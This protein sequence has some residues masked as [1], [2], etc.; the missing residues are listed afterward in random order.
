VIAEAHRSRLAVARL[1]RVRGAAR[2]LLAAFIVV[3]PCVALAAGNYTV[4][5]R[6]GKR[7]NKIQEALQAENYN[8]AEE[9]LKGFTMARLNPYERALVYQFWGYVEAG[10][11][12]YQASADYF[13]K[14]L[15]E[16]ALPDE[17]A[18]NMR[19][20]IAQLYMALNRWDDA[21][22]ALELW[23]TQVPEPNSNAYYTLAIAYYQKSEE[24][25]LP[26]YK[27]KALV[28]A[29][30][31]VEL[32]KKPQERWLQ[33]LLAL[34]MEKKD[35]KDS[36][37]LLERLVSLYPKKSYWI[38][39]SAIYGELEMDKQSLAAQQLAY[40]QGLLDKD[41]EL[42][43]LAE[44]YL[45]YELPYRA[46]KVLE[47]GF[48]A[49][50]VERDK[51]SLELYANALVA[52]KE[53]DAAVEPLG[54]AAAISDTGDLYMRLGQVYVDREDWTNAE[55]AFRDALDKGGMREACRSELLLGITVY[56]LGKTGDARNWFKRA[57]REKV[58]E[59]Y[60]QQWLEHLEREAKQAASGG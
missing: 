14:C 43:R 12:D 30:K 29:R 44:L 7:L 26:E 9:L 17:T 3:I 27:E 31:A 18:I 2:A 46:V 24:D 10:R 25:N 37:P 35:Y 50:T 11:E 8:D 5:E 41:K 1:G 19:F 55:K 42:R 47:E 52:A 16:N 20:N 15:A 32:A 53:Y 23:F 58:C 13:E 38:Q 22:K 21:I 4:N 40:A 6:T 39:L 60:A 34:Y 59:T 57:G 45:Y 49:G 51:K 56:N 33:L 48:K 36:L 28:P 54:E